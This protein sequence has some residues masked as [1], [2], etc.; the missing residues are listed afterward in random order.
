MEAANLNK[1]Y[2]GG[3]L[4]QVPTEE[5][6]VARA[7]SNLQSEI[8]GLSV[9]VEVACNRVAVVS[10]PYPAAPCADEKTQVVPTTSLM[11]KKIDDQAGRIRM[12]TNQLNSAVEALE[13]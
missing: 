8:N 3:A 2:A 13:I 5:S 1:S 4:G 12:L 9:A 7:M 10:C 11:V 6:K